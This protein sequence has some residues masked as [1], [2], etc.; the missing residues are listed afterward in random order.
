VQTK[1]SALRLGN[2]AGQLVGRVQRA[3]DNEH[4]FRLI[5]RFELRAGP[6]QPAMV[7]TLTGRTAPNLSR[8]VSR[9]DNKNHLQA[10]VIDQA[11]PT[12]LK[13]VRFAIVVTAF[14]HRHALASVLELAFGPTF[15][16]PSSAG[17][18]EPCA[19]HWGSSGSE[20]LMEGGD[21]DQ[22]SFD[23]RANPVEIFHLLLI[24]ALS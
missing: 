15:D 8:P 22:Q 13:C 1:C 20:T 21:C 17:W 6:P 11:R 4:F 12:L 5:S 2:F 16:L 19:L 24:G 23:E 3:S 14:A 10:R 18:T 7:V 9:P